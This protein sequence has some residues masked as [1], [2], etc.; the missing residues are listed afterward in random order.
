MRLLVPTLASILVA[1]AVALAV[2]SKATA[3]GQPRAWPA[4]V[5]EVR[6]AERLRAG[7][8]ELVRHAE[9]RLGN[10]G[11]IAY[12]FERCAWVEERRPITL[13]VAPVKSD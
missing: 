11:P 1:G 9:R 4:T 10:P 6:A 3:D 7:Q 8:A 2:A 5:E 12:D 13:E